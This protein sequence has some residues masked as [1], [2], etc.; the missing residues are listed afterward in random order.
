[1][2]EVWLAF[3]TLSDET[4]ALKLLSE[5]LRDDP[6]VRGRMLRELK[7]GRRVTHPNVCRVHD[8][9]RHGNRLFVTMEFVEGTDLA[10]LLVA[11]HSSLTLKRRFDLAIQIAEALR[12]I[13]AAGLVHR[14]LK[15]SNILVDSRGVVRVTDFGLARDVAWASRSAEPAT[16]PL[17]GTAGYMS[18]EQVLGQKL[19]ARSDLYSL[20]VLVYE[21]FTGLPLFEGT[22]GERLVGSLKK[23]PPLALRSW[24]NLPSKVV[25]FLRKCLRRN[26]QSRLAS[27]SL[28]LEDLRAASDAVGSELRRAGVEDLPE[29]Q[30]LSSNTR[31]FRIPS[32][33]GVKWSSG[34]RRRGSWRVYPPGAPIDLKLSVARMREEGVTAGDLARL[35]R[36][37]GELDP[38]SLFGVMLEAGRPGDALTPDEPGVVALVGRALELA[39]ENVDLTS[40][41][42]EGLARRLLSRV[43]PSISSINLDARC[44]GVP[45]LKELSNRQGLRSLTISGNV[46]PEI[47]ALPEW[48]SIALSAALRRL[49]LLLS[50]YGEAEPPPPSW[51]QAFRGLCS[52][53][54]LGVA[55]ID[56]AHVEAICSL[57]QLRKLTLAGKCLP[58]A[59]ATLE[60]MV[61][62]PAP[63]GLV[64]L[65]LPP[66]LVVNR[67]A[68]ERLCRKFPAIRRLGISLELDA[69][70]VLEELPFLESLEASVRAS[71]RWPLVIDGVA[72]KLTCSIPA[73]HQLALNCCGWPDFGELTLREKKARVRT[74][75]EQLDWSSFCTLAFDG[76]RLVSGPKMTLQ[77][78]QVY[79][80][81]LV[82]DFEGALY[83]AWQSAKGGRPQPS[84]WGDCELWVA[85]GGDGAAQVTARLDLFSRSPALDPNEDECTTLGWYHARSP[86]ELEAILREQLQ[87]PLGPWCS[88]TGVHRR[89]I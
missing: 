83:R 89:G 60:T 8:L 50:P 16:G 67:P 77:N 27:A 72:T 12:A 82:L 76:V 23:P 73:L 30:R 17:I 84:T 56:V 85:R 26:R 1:M 18:P 20:G 35:A 41:A 69:L 37:M 48:R 42:D 79:D 40:V 19:D 15:P 11:E 45:V 22:Y 10:R 47:W 54:I 55:A 61:D 44:L 66:G 5:P 62:S 4:I 36:A 59:R 39:G 74:L 33:P 68:A 24:W 65:E 81:G 46:R 58:D 2:G 57:P 21:I 38:H 6:A 80:P 3:D 25:R 28:A 9:G 34:G 63:A 71:G 75:S 14:D 29:D 64:W 51:L 86:L 32:F 87:R 43:Q 52:L 88:V 78:P 31:A 49:N 70:P 53:N 13:H 7:A